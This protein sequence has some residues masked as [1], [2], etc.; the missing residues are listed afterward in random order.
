MTQR[1]VFYGVGNQVDGHQA[2][3]RAV[4]KAVDGQTHAI[5]GD[6][7]FVGKVLGKGQGGHHL[8]QPAFADLFKSTYHAHAI[9]M[10]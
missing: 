7:A 8:Q 3:L 2:T 6:R 4:F 9:H 1:G 5:D 10:P